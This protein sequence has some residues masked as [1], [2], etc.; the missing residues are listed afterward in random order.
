MRVVISCLM[1]GL[2]AA[3]CVS[4]HQV[5]RVEVNQPGDDQLQ[6]ED[7]LV[8]VKRNHI[9]M[10]EAQ[11]NIDSVDGRNATVIGVAILATLLAGPPTTLPLDSDDDDEIAL[12]AYE[13][14]HEKLKTIA[15][16]LGCPALPE[17]PPEVVEGLAE[18]KVP[19]SVKEEQAR[20]DWVKAR[21]GSSE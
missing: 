8:E 21:A 16:D 14:R 15:T 11:D 3:G 17:P 4:K 19:D 7:I 5:E 10:A 6:C 2:L 1:T 13:R 12:L 18:Q 9:D 20:S